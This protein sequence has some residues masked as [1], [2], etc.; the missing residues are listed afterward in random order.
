MAALHPVSFVFC[1]LFLHYL[2]S[3]YSA[4]GKLLSREACRA[5]KRDFPAQAS[6]LFTIYQSQMGRVLNSQ[7][8]KCVLNLDILLNAPGAEFSSAV[9]LVC[10]FVS[11]GLL[12]STSETKLCREKTVKAGLMSQCAACTVRIKPSGSNCSHTCILNDL[13][14]KCIQIRKQQRQNENSLENTFFFLL[15]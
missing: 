8:E 7:S 2:A 4:C 9:C 1:H 11:L 14:N 5:L 15:C 10:V 3:H 13:L 6:V 12:L